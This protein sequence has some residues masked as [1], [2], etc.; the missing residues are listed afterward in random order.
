VTIRGSLAGFPASGSATAKLVVI[1]RQAPTGGNVILDWSRCGAPPFV[2]YQD[3]DGAWTRADVAGNVARFTVSSSKGGFAYA[4]NEGVTVRFMT[5][6]ELTAS[7]IDVCP[8]KSGTNTV[9]GTARSVSSSDFFTYSLG[10]GVGTSNTNAPNITI[11]GIRDGVHDLV[12]FGSQLATG[13]AYLARDIEIPA[14]TSI[15]VVDLGGPNAFAV[16]RANVNV[17]GFVNSDPLVLT[18]NYLTTSAC[19]SNFLYTQALQGALSSQMLGFP[20]NVQRPTDFHSLAMTAS[21]PGQVRT[22][23][24]TFHTF[25]NVTVTIQPLLGS[26]TLDVAAGPYLRER[27]TFGVIPAPY[28]ASVSLRY[29]EGRHTMAVVA[30][31]GYTGSNNPVLTMP[32]LSGVAGWQASYAYAPGAAGTWSASADGSNGGAPCTEGRLTYNATVNGTLP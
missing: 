6:A 27:A 12:G 10:G 8:L 3:G 29:S 1:V 18:L 23:T 11:N 21:R 2:A 30:S 14:V 15:G 25:G 28:N 17:I 22:T 32:D 24:A 13:R 5:Q 31:I 9:T 16:A 20:E 26:P 19:T 4:D 7:P